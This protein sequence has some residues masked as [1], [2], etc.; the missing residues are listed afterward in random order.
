MRPVRPKEGLMSVA[1]RHHL[2]KAQVYLVGERS[3]FETAQTPREVYA[4]VEAAA[5]PQDF[6]ELTLATNN[7]WNGKPLFVR[8][9]FVAA[10]APPTQPEDADA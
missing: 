7:A 9:C 4:L 6:V 8:A 2:K 5:M 1:T 3:A 10:I